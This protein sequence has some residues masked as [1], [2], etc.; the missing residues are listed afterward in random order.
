MAF[1]STILI[2]LT[3]LTLSGCG[4]SSESTQARAEQRRVILAV[5]ARAESLD[6][7]VGTSLASYRL[8]QLLFSYLIAQ[9]ME[10]ELV[11]EVASGW[12][13][14]PTE[15][16]GERYVFS[17]RDDV[18]FHDGTLLTADDVVY[19]FTTLVDPDFVSAKKGA[20][21]E[22][23][24]V[25]ARDESSVVFEF[26]APQRAFLSNLPAVGIVKAGSGG[27]VPMGSGP[28]ILEQRR[29]SE[30]YVFSSHSNY[31]LGKPGIDTLEVRVVPDDTTRAL[32][33]M[34]G[35]V[36]IIVND[37]SITDAHY[38]SQL[39]A[40]KMVR[41]PGLA[42]QYLG[43][44]HEHAILADVRVR[45]ALAFAIDRNTIINEFM[46]AM[47]RAAESPIVPALWKI[48]VA[49]NPQ[50][51]DPD[52]AKELLDSAGYPDPD[53]AGPE[54]RFTLG[55]RCSNNRQSREFAA[56]LKDMLSDVG[57]GLDIRS[58]EW[59]TFYMDVVNGRYELYSLRWVGIID[60]DF[61]GALFHSNSIPGIEKDPAERDRGSLNRGRYRNP[62][63]D[64]L[65]VEAE[66]AGSEAERWRI[67]AAMQ[68]VID[69]D[70][71]YIDLWYADN[72]A[73]MRADLSDIQLPLNGSF[74]TLRHLRY[75]SEP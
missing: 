41:S 35:S 15:S 7:R 23:V 74:A 57:I 65:I 11:A 5:D 45:T 40:K 29:G 13:S 44:N 70:L 48:K 62:Q 30:S 37:L 21:S 4:A 39:P 14:E 56:I 58:T 75:T 47:V 42:Y 67:Y 25:K 51:Y 3:V 68:E 55:Y 24:S 43:I 12:I 36:D 18:T 49:P 71:P 54:P 61:Y 69:V 16:G 26:S 10:G 52:R 9:G 19:T 22:L 50:L 60:P 38:L 28:F 27:E 72:F 53:G 17:L 8:Q 66:Q 59:Q 32:E 1:R 33:F 2:I 63:L 46:G 73:V 34:H 31:F 20:F 6:P 64:T